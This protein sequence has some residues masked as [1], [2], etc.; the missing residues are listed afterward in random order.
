MFLQPSTSNMFND[1]REVFAWELATGG[2][3]QVALSGAGTFSP[4]ES[5]R[6]FYAIEF[7]T[8]SVVDTAVF[9]TAVGGQ[10]IYN[11]ASATYSGFTFPAGYTWTAP[12]TQLTLDSGTGIAYE[13][14]INPYLD[15]NPVC[16]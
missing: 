4:T 3:G 1:R 6:V 10:T 13:Y 9:R 5:D 8:E 7:L 11:V 16:P 14:K 2:H 12:L 15:G